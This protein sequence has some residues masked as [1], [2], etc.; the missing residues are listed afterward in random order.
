MGA[1]IL[2]TDWLQA[3]MGKGRLLPADDL[4]S[5]ERVLAASP[6]SGREP[7]SIAE[8]RLVGAYRLR[9]ARGG[10]EFVWPT[11]VAGEPEAWIYAVHE[12][13]ELQ[14]FA[15]LNANPFRTPSFSRALG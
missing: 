11:I 1:Y 15:D 12:A 7:F 14:A 2:A 9:V 8:V 5:A 10:Y 3:R 4:G 13:A 6:V